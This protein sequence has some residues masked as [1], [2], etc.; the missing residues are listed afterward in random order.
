MVMSI[1]ETTK[2]RLEAGGSEIVY[3]A[4][5]HLGAV[6]YLTM[7][8]FANGGGK[9][10]TIT[11]TH[12]GGTVTRTYTA[13]TDF[14]AA[15]SN[16]VT[17]TNM[18][19]AVNR[20]FLINDRVSVYVF[21]GS[22][23]VLCINGKGHK[24]R[25]QATT[26]A[27][28]VVVTTSEPT[29]WNIVHE[30]LNRIYRFV[31]T[32]TQAFAVDQIVDPTNLLIPE[33][34]S[35]ENISAEIDPLT[36]EFSIGD[37][38]IVFEDPNETSVFRE[39]LKRSFPKGAFV[40]L[41]MGTP[42]LTTANFI[43]IGG[44]LIDDVVPSFGTITVTC[45]E[46]PSIL[47][48]RRYDNTRSPTP[49]ISF[50]SDTLNSNYRVTIEVQHP[51][52]VI[53]RT[54]TEGLNGLV[55]SSSAAGTFEN[56]L[57]A[58]NAD[59]EL[60]DRAVAIYNGSTA[61][62]ARLYIVP[63]PDYTRPPLAEENRATKI[64]VRVQA[65][66]APYLSV[67]Y[68]YYSFFAAT[69]FNQVDYLSPSKPGF[70][71]AN[72]IT[73]LRD[74]YR[75]AGID[76]SL[77][78]EASFRL[79]SNTDVSH[80]SVS[81][82]NNLW[83]DPAADNSPTGDCL[84]MQEKLSQLVQGGIVSREDGKLTFIRR[85]VNA[86]PIRHLTTDDYDEFEWQEQYTNTINKLIIN[87]TAFGS[88]PAFYVQCVSVQEDFS[89]S[90]HSF[91][92]TN[93]KEEVINHPYLGTYTQMLNT[94][95]DSSNPT[96]ITVNGA[97][98]SG[99][100]GSSQKMSHD[101]TAAQATERLIGIDR[102]AY[103]L[104]WAPNSG[105]HEI[106]KATGSSAVPNAEIYASLAFGSLS[107]TALRLN[108]NNVHVIQYPFLIFNDYEYSITRAQKNTTIVDF[109]T[110]PQPILIADITIPVMIAEHYMTF[111]YGSPTATF[112]TTLRHFDLQLG[113]VI[114]HDNNQYLNFLADGAG[115]DTTWEIIGKELDLPF[116]KFTVVRLKRV[117]TPI[118][119][120]NFY[121][122]P[123]VVRGSS[124]QAQLDVNVYDNLDQLVTTDTDE[125][126]TI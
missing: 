77:L 106:V 105:I 122:P 69:T 21:T 51:T 97:W 41:K 46:I 120:A 114:T 82:N 80:L 24:T 58:I 78:D 73:V 44:F 117:F 83:M 60:T 1:P 98:Q 39:L 61:N 124:S 75:F 29:A 103:F 108:A 6:A 18:A 112:R 13:G 17:A 56:L 96:T 52:G 33:I 32:T 88:D 12:S 48:G 50:V 38:E 26:L 90:V 40:Q 74:I 15:T 126:V 109:T 35:V 115:T 107:E 16:E 20:D 100:C 102:P 121:N 31:S 87:G 23:I 55:G 3:L 53:V 65:V 81:A 93:L 47:E 72:P 36:R 2:A 99:F 10:F 89:I 25:I 113:D 86:S 42:A 123:V 34:R 62:T 59:T 19:D 71:N 63:F 14:T 22:Q 111:A 110:Q 92:D 101:N 125:P 68:L 70:V 85:N 8:N 9:S 66:D 57:A 5:M 94:I 116:V 76:S 30:P 11:M 27:D 67:D 54:Y 95:P 43:N 28:T 118:S 7:I 49:A 4:E 37:I 84:D 64:K 91:K 79:S 104:I 119:V 45:R